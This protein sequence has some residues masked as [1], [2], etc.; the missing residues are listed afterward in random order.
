MKMVKKCLTLLCAIVLLVS[1]IT[2]T[3]AAD[4]IVR[5][6]A[7]AAVYQKNGVSI[8]NGALTGFKNNPQAFATFTVQSGEAGEQ[9]VKINY[10]VDGEAQLTV[11]VNGKKAG[12]ASFTQGEN[13]TVELAVTLE[14]GE[15]K[16]ALWNENDTV[17]AELMIEGIEVGGQQYAAS[18]AFYQHWSMNFDASHAG[19]SGNGFVAGFYSNCGAHIQFTV[20]VSADGEYDV[21]V[22]YASGNNEA[23]GQAAKLGVYVNGD[24]QTDTLLKPGQT[25]DTYLTK[26]EQLTLKKGT[27]T[28]TYWYEDSS[29][30]AAPNFD[31]IEVLP[32]GTAVD[33]ESDLK[34]VEETIAEHNQTVIPFTVTPNKS[35]TMEAEEA[36]WI[37]GDPFKSVGEV[38]EHSGYTGTGFVAGL[39]N[40]AGS[41]VEFPLDVMKAGSYTLTV[42]YA[43]GAGAAPVGI[44]VDG[45]LLAKYDFVSSGGWSSWGEFTIEIELTAESNSV[46]LL[47][48][49]GEGEFGINLDSI[50]LTPVVID[51][52][53]EDPTDDPSG[54]GS[55]DPDQKPAEKPATKPTDAPQSGSTN[56]EPEKDN[57]LVWVIGAA[58]LI[59]CLAI[60]TILIFMKKATKKD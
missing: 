15:N 57:T 52:P 30:I 37:M 4:Q 55:D 1:T 41:G 42:R 9:N 32:K 27:N 25:W 19:Y 36:L 7:E 18:G 43:N 31:Y 38:K 26:T 16:I 6:E 54:E 50:S 2:I 5:Y 28:I 24:K 34:S 22:G 35:V 21:T 58:V 59:P 44:Y 3:A 48:E 29:V 17:N 13:Q 39:W 49:T 51:E 10:T 47:S 46:K 45:E 12:E 11:L 40:N 53:S 23:R 33:E 8:R 56:V 60:V 20:E 14:N